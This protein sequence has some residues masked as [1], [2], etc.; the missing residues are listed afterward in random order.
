MLYGPFRECPDWL[1]RT[2]TTSSLTKI[3]FIR[4]PRD[5]LVSH[6]FISKET[7]ST[8]QPSSL[9]SDDFNIQ[10]ESHYPNIDVHVLIWA[11]YFRLRFERYCMLCRI[12]PKFHVYRY[13]DM[14]A[15]F[16]DWIDDLVKVLQL[17][18]TAPVM[19]EVDLIK[20]TVTLENLIE[21]PLAHHRLGRP[22]DFVNKLRGETLEE[23][24]HYFSDTLKF[25]G[26][27]N[28]A[29]R[30]RFQRTVAGAT[31]GN[32]ETELTRR[33]LDIFSREN[34]LRIAEIASLRE[35]LADLRV[36]AQK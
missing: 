14:A 6:H 8:F 9:A 36:N 29:A 11:R 18:A 1:L 33:Q 22:G 12:D 28:F 17:P 13:E 24:A 5:C 20:A 3:L 4:D 10:R 23:L 27:D 15:N 34:G 32:A 7:H 30:T 25:Y 19:E 2:L 16:S 31:T 35:S 26:Y 21:D